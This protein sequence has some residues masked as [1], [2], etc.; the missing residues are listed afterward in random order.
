MKLFAS[1][2]LGVFLT[3]FCVIIQRYINSESKVNQ[4]RAEL[5]NLGHYVEQ[6]KKTCGLLPTQQIAL[7]ALTD[8]SLIN[9]KIKP[10]FDDIPKDPDGNDFIY[11]E[12]DNAVYIVSSFKK[13]GYVEIKK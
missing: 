11:L 13:S 1:F 3:L 8:P 4:S 10:I 5:Y 6:L 2:I 12:N 7:K 9:C